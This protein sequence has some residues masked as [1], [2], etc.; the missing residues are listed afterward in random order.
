MFGRLFGFGAKP[1]PI[2]KV[3]LPLPSKYRQRIQ[4]NKQS[5]KGMVYEMEQKYRK[6]LTKNTSAYWNFI[7]NPI[8]LQY[9][10]KNGNQE[11]QK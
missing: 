10:P 9:V 3:E 1:A 6:L 5:V 4:E 2:Q 11:L 8:S 7:S